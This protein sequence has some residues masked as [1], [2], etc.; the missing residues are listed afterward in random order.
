MYELAQVFIKRKM[1]QT[2]ALLVLENFAGARHRE[3][4]LIDSL[5]AN[6]AV[7]LLARRLYFRG[8]IRA[9]GNARLRIEQK[10]ELKDDFALLKLL[11]TEFESYNG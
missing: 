5:N 3:T 4:M 10:G 9:V 6:K 1:G 11:Q 7:K 8:D 2:E